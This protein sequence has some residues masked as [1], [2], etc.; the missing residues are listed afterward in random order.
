MLAVN[1]PTVFPIAQPAQ[2]IPSELSELSCE[3][4]GILYHDSIDNLQKCFS[5]M[6]PNRQKAR[7]VIL[8]DSIANGRASSATESLP[9]VSACRERA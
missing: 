3:L 7:F 8:V 4:L 2:L 6:L 9:N 5:N 1:T